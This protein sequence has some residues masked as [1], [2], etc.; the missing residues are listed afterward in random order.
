M[1]KFK[2]IYIEITNHCNLACSFCHPSQRSQSFMS[3][4]TFE[5][6]IRQLNGFTEHLYLHVL[7][8][9]L[10]HPDLATLLDLCH[11]QELRV[12]LTTNGTLLGRCQS[13]LL[14]S[15]ALRQV[16][17]SL[18][19]FEEM[20]GEGLN[21][22]LDEILDFVRLA[23]ASTALLINL[24]LWK[25]PP[26]PDSEEVEA[27]HRIIRRLETGFPQ[28]APIRVERAAGQGITLAPGVFLSQA[29]QFTWPHASKQDFGDRGACRGLKDHLAILVDG[30][31]VPCCLDAEADIPLGNILQT[32]LA[33]ILTSPRATALSQ[34][35][36][37]RRL[38]ESLCRGCS[39]RQRF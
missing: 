39:F 10:L 23:R 31:V 36:S 5:A 37:Q 33:H 25:L 11:H 20:A 32:P 19:S 14:G 27:H 21:S 18:H 28:A 22:Y 12:N 16:N 17:I 34:G 8:E 29:P 4:S 9:P 7:G 2:K 26:H 30:T 1:K 6:I 13:D 3:P 24:R 38:V 35:F 15:A